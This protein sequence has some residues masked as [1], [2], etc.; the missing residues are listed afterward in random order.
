MIERSIEQMPVTL[1]E[2]YRARRVLGIGGMA[3]VYLAD[4]AVSGQQVAV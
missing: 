3:I 4:D 2:R 1:P